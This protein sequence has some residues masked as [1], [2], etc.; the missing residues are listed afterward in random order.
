MLDLEWGDDFMIVEVI[1]LT[2]SLERVVCLEAVAEISVNHRATVLT[3]PVF[4]C[5]ALLVLPDD[6]LL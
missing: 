2:G 3:R 1:E 4:F 6:L 5:Y